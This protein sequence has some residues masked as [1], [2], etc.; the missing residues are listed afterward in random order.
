MKAYNF[1][2]PKCRFDG[3]TTEQKREM[4]GRNENKAG[5]A[6][7]DRIVKA[8]SDGQVA[9]NVQ[10]PHCDG[11]IPDASGTPGY[12][13]MAIVGGQL[14][15]ENIFPNNAGLTSNFVEFRSTTLGRIIH[16]EA[17]MKDAY[18]EMWAK[19]VAKAEKPSEEVQAAPKP[20]PRVGKKVKAGDEIVA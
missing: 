7:Y 8:N 5:F 2:C 11:M 14:G 18:L 4:I 6:K 9:D 16:D 15:G 13:P 20:T 3:L 17:E 10:C 1:E 19:K 12:N